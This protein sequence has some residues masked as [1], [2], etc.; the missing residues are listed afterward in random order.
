MSTCKIDTDEKKKLTLS[1]NDASALTGLSYGYLRNLCLN[2]RVVFI[3]CGNKYMINRQSLIDFIN[4][5][6]SN[7][8]ESD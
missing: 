3:R 8:T 4:T 1:L 6:E 7:E 5:G 2:H